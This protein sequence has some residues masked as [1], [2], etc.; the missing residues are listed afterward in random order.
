MNDNG[1]NLLDEP[2]IM[3]LTPSG[4]EK[5]ASILDVFEMAPELVTVGG[6]VPTQGFAITRMLLAFLHRAVDGPASKDDW[7]ELWQADTLPLDRIHEYA[8]RYRNRFDLF[9]PEQPFFQVS[10]LRTA[11]GEVSGLEKIVAD[12]PN[13]AP[14]FTTRSAASLDRI[15]AAE[16]ARWLVHAHA[17]DAS[18][19]KSGAVGDRN[20][21]GGKGYPIGTGWSGQIGGVLP[22]GRNLRETLLLNLIGRDAETYLR[23]GGTADVPPWER[24]SD[25][26]AWDD[27]RPPRGAI[28]MYTWQTRRVRLAGGRA[29]VTGVVLAN[30][31]KILPQNRHIYDPHSVWR[32]SE[33]QTKKYGHT[34]NMPRMHNPTRAVWRGL[35]AMLPSVY[36][37]RSSG[38]EPQAFLAP[39]VMQ[40]ISSLVV[41]DHL[42]EDYVVRTRAIG[43][44]Y[45]AQSATFTEM[46]D[47]SLTMAVALV[48]EQSVALGNTA[49]GAVDD[50]KKAASAVWKFA[51]NVARAGGA[52]PKSGA[53]D[54]TEEALY[55]ALE[56]P[57]RRWLAGLTSRTDTGAARE[58][59]QKVVR[60][61]CWPVVREV[62][63]AAGPA[64]WRG[65]EVNKRL[66]NV[67]VAEAWLR[68]ALRQALPRAFPDRRATP[69][70]SPGATQTPRE[71]TT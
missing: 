49:K 1:F 31:D 28:D 69:E 27:N 38:T 16:A 37:R 43:A 57:Y 26:A 2:W 68:A 23:I 71:E 21:K 33:P 55:A 65:R 9:D 56:E 10:D 24:K 50:A 13:G 59:W 32:Y 52:E 30:G 58:V 7:T 45:G 35:A 41:N 60:D 6:E 11:K 47:E 40:W 51:E 20:V 18:G 54:R 42:P 25:S 17:F 63:E 8:D 62:I 64:A 67:S 29:G 4:D 19:I 39:G 5:Q 36:G 46:I 3:V 48:S 44:E 61:R 53:G 66:V 22:E 70:T 12:V 15:E 14:Y 34:V